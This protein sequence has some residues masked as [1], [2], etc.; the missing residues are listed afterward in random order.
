MR[1]REFEFP[2][3]SLLLEAEASFSSCRPRSSEMYL[4]E[5][6]RCLVIALTAYS[7][8]T[9][10]DCREA[11]DRT[12]GQQ[13][14]LTEITSGTEGEFLWE[15]TVW[16]LNQ[17]HRS[18]RT[19]SVK[20]FTTML[21]A[22]NKTYA[23][24]LLNQPRGINKININVKTRKVVLRDCSC[25]HFFFYLRCHQSSYQK[26]VIKKKK[27]L[28]WIMWCLWSSAEHQSVGK[29]WRHPVMTH[30]TDVMSHL[31]RYTSIT[32]GC[33]KYDSLYSLSSSHP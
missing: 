23:K 18:T 14:R 9:V 19:E 24:T 7:V 32:A 28:L 8:H 20:S 3:W 31:Y 29:Q 27:L 26:T 11:W 2:V 1:Y 5:W 10:C 15:V 22:K 13:A 30:F 33:Q 16:I 25:N 6:N 4:A 12:E 21:V 17:S